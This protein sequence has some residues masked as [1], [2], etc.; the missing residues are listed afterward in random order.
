[1]SEIQSI[2]QNNYILTTQQEVSHDNSLSGNGTV[3]SPIGVVPGY[4]ETVLW[5][6]AFLAQTNNTATITEP[7][8]NFETIK[9]YASRDNNQ[10]APIASEFQVISSTDA[11]YCIENTFYNSTGAFY[12]DR[13]QINFN[14]TTVRCVLDVRLTYSTTGFTINTGAPLTV[15]KII[16]INRIANN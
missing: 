4:N 13:A 9:I 14:N 8:T 12:N 2:T 6:G 3:D 5:S 7:I 11:P 15:S 10:R 1:M 16:G